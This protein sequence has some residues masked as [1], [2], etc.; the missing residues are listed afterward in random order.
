MDFF[1]LRGSLN[2]SQVMIQSGIRSALSNIFASCDNFTSLEVYVIA[3]MFS[4]TW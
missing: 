3:L 4:D 1:V 2:K